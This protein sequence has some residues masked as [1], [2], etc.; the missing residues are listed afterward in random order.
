VKR[1]ARTPADPPRGARLGYVFFGRRLPDRHAAW[2]HHDVVSTQWRARQL[3]VASALA[4]GV[5]A[6]ITLCLALYLGGISP[7]ARLVM[8]AAVAAAVIVFFGRSDRDPARVLGRHHLRA[9]GHWEPHPARVSRTSRTVMTALGIAVLAGAVGYTI[10]NRDLL[11]ASDIAGGCSE[12]SADVEDGIVR[13][14]AEEIGPLRA[15]RT[16]DRT[17]VAAVVGAEVAEWW[18]LHD[19]GD[20]VQALNEPAK[21]VTPHFA[22]T[23]VDE[24]SIAFYAEQRVL[25]GSCATAAGLPEGVDR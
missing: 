8:G 7:D 10:A 6:V 18:V 11:E 13:F 12:V 21:R 2:V 19:F 5:G 14:T 25:A 3:L 16:A 15:V 4:V 24:A 9:D 17:L 1:A 20:E 23:P 22:L